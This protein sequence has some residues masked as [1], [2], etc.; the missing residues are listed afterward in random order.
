M[1]PQALHH[2]TIRPKDIEATKEFYEKVVKLT[3]GYRPP[4][5]FPGYW[6]YVGEIPAVHLVGEGAPLNAY[7]SDEGGPDHEASGGGAVD[8]VAF[9][10]SPKDFEKMKENFDLE[11]VDHL[12]TVVPEL[13]LRQIFLKDPDGV[14]V[15]LLFPAE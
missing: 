13:G 15:E 7:F 1:E 8:H 14:R 6:L 12:H 9:V 3:V 5:D 2:L 4:F 10:F 11:G